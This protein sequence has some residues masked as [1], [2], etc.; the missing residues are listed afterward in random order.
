M[1]CGVHEKFRG[2]GLSMRDKAASD[3]TKCKGQNKLGDILMALRQKLNSPSYLD[4]KNTPL[5]SR[6]SVVFTSMHT[7]Y[8]VNFKVRH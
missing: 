4:Y 3:S 6:T 8:Y 2:T 7:G 1:F 5:H